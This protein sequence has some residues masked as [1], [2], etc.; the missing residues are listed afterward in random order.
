MFK[1]V[2]GESCN[3]TKNF[4]GKVAIPPVDSLASKNLLVKLSLQCGMAAKCFG[5]LILYECCTPNEIG[6]A[7]AILFQDNSHQTL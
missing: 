6:D 4:D 5:H 1:L 3:I 2:A 7:K